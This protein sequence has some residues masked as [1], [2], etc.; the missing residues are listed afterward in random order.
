[1]LYSCQPLHHRNISFDEVEQYLFEKHN[2]EINAIFGD[3]INY[4]LITLLNF[5]SE[6]LQ[7]SSPHPGSWIRITYVQT[8]NYEEKFI[9]WH[10]GVI[11]RRQGRNGTMT[12]WVRVVDFPFSIGFLDY[13]EK[14]SQIVDKDTRA[15]VHNALNSGMSIEAF[16]SIMQWRNNL[17]RDT[18]SQYLVCEFVARTASLPIHP[19][20]QRKIFTFLIVNYNDKN[21]MFI[22][23]TDYNPSHHFGDKTIIYPYEMTLYQ[24]IEWLTDNAETQRS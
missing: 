14:I 19:F 6:F 23:Q 18:I 13:R 12:D 9:V 8:V 2:I 21:K 7:W 24:F 20:S 22:L 11:S 1:M 4:D 5:Y 17:E 15:D 16:I 3:F 10:Q